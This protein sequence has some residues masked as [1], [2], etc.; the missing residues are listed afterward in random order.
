MK[1]ILGLHRSTTGFSLL[2]VLIAVVV[3]SVGLLALAALQGAL[4]RSSS[5][6]K[7]R[8]RVAAMLS[9]RMEDLRAH[10]YGSMAVGPSTTTSTTAVCG[11]DTNNF[12]TDT[13]WIDCARIQ[14]AVGSITVQQVVSVWFGA[15]SFASSNSEQNSAI[16][17]FKRV[18]LSATWTDANGVDHTQSIASDVSSM[19]LT[20]NM[21]IPPEPLSTPTGGPIVRTA[22]PAT[23][24]V[25][26]IALSTNEETGEGESFNATTNPTPELVGQSN[27]QQIVGTRFTV[28][29]YTPST[30]GNSAV[31]LQKRFDTE[32]VK[33]RCKFGAGGPNLPP[34][35]QEEM[36]PAIWTGEGYEVYDAGTNAAPGAS[37][38]SG[39]A[40]GVEQSALC[41]EC[42]RDHHD[43]GATDVPRFD[44]E[45]ESGITKFDVNPQGALVPVSD[46]GNGDYV[47]S[48]RLVRVDGFWRTASDV[49]ERQHG[50][51]PTQTVN[52]VEAKSGLPTTAAVQAYESFVKTHLG[53]FDGS[54]ANEA[55]FGQSAQD[56]FD[57]TA[58]FDANDINIVSAAPTDYRYLHSRGLYVDYLEEKAREK[59]TEALD[60][61]NADSPCVDIPD[62]ECVL[63]FLPFTTVNLTELTEWLEMPQNQTQINV[64]ERNLLSTTPAQPSGGRTVGITAGHADARTSNRRSSSGL[65]VSS[66]LTLVQG[67]D[68]EDNGEVVESEYDYADQILHDEQGFQI[69]EGTGKRF[70]VVVTG[71]GGNPFV[72]F[73]ILPDDNVE[74]LKPSGSTHVCATS[75]GIT[76]PQLTTIT[77]ARYWLVGSVSESMT[78]QC[79]TRSATAVVTRPTFT[80]YRVATAVVAGGT[81]TIAAPVDDI[82]KNETTTITF[83]GIDEG[84]TA[85]IGLVAEGSPLKATIASCTTNGNG[86]QIR[87]IVWNEVWAQP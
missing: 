65:A 69:G 82:T 4:T 83:S 11:D 48:C 58:A 14:A 54:Q 49:Y 68:P 41:Q 28:L 60:D 38:N 32:V 77:L 6:A 23:A 44:P 40:S 63:P 24:G 71:S 64:N 46:M 25:I 55:N 70:N 26:P 39:P 1:R 84:A 73:T 50:L 34:I 42:C 51:L 80:N 61:S 56:A 87:N 35:Y 78:A 16:P 13:D 15:A 31:I 67:V 2:E 17:Q 22:S 43:S 81:A 30:F 53:Q 10:G 20:N 85:Q 21:I 57:A 29:N 72:F 79:A 5:E 19:A 75:S 27:N 7:V 74:C 36:W 12:Q 33:C 66:T 37:L 18:V 47:D 62:E 52:G 76:L 3:L 9:T 86:T 45:R 59:L 8:G